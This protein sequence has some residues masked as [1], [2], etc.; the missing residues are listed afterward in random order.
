MIM[1]KPLLRALACL[2]L[3]AFVFSLGLPAVADAASKAPAGFVAL[4]ESPMAWKDAAAFCQQKG[5]R[6]PRINNSDSWA[7]ADLGKITHIDGF[8]APNAPWPSGLPEGVS[9]WTGTENSP[10]HSWIVVG[11]GIVL[12]AG[13][14]SQGSEN[15]VACVPAGASGTPPP[16]PPPPPPPVPQ[17]ADAAKPT[18]GGAVKPPLTGAAK[19]PPGNAATGGTTTQRPPA[20]GPGD[21]APP[22]QTVSP[23]KPPKA[24][25]KADPAP[26][27]DTKKQTALP[28]QKETVYYKCP[29]HQVEVGLIHYN[30][31]NYGFASGMVMT[32]LKRTGDKFTPSV[33]ANFGF[34]IK[35]NQVF[36]MKFNQPHGPCQIVRRAKTTYQDPRCK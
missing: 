12:A 29:G 18:P 35:N 30:G 16:P 23:P 7:L 9:F 1:T 36:L 24:P 17:P 11:T 10:D 28:G 8:G 34:E 22:T 2:A 20:S 33:G 19:P 25:A 4:S 14:N 26:P 31:D 13:N 21:A 27:A 15:R 32:C 3:L 6:L 5:G